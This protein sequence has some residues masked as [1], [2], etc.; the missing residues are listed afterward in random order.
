[1]GVW[2]R[3]MKERAR[4]ASSLLCLHRRRETPIPIPIPIPCPFPLKRGKG[5]QEF[6]EPRGSV[7]P[8]AQPSTP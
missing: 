7:E 2:S 3:A 1:M 6:V 4:E 5:S 8:T